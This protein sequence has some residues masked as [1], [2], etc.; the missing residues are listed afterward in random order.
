M[1]NNRGNEGNFGNLL[2]TVNFFFYLPRWE[3]IAPLYVFYLFTPSPQPNKLE[4]IE[5]GKQKEAQIEGIFLCKMNKK[6]R[7][8]LEYLGNKIIKIVVRND[9]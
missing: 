2:L 4:N 3:I 7:K 8:N 1:I 6:G 5:W 9:N